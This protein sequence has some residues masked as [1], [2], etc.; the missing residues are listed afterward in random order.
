MPYPRSNILRSEEAKAKF[1]A[2]PFFA[3]W[4]PDVLDTYVEFGLTEDADGGV[5]LKL[6]G[7]H[8]RP[9]LP[10]T[11]LHRSVD[12]PLPLGSPHLHGGDDDV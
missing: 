5:K 10:V 4:H 6:P 9:N 3:A 1:L 2:S 8:V 7:I 11:H 12:A